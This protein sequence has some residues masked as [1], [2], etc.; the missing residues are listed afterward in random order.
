[1]K[2]LFFEFPEDQGSYENIASNY[3]IGPAI[4]IA[5]EINYIYFDTDYFYFP[6][7]TWCSLFEPIGSCITN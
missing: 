5:Y 6:A 7:G 3:M 1:M 2:P 4:K